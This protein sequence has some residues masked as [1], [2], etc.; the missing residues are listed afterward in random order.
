MLALSTS[1]TIVDAPTA[2]AIAA[3]AFFSASATALLSEPNAAR[4]PVASEKLPAIVA[5]ILATPFNNSSGLNG[6]II[7]F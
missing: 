6:G 5:P 4:T 3:C 1:R 7:Y 2:M